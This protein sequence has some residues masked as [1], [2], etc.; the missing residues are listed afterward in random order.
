MY[1]YDMKE[2]MNVPRLA[3]GHGYK[4]PE[5]YGCCNTGMAPSIFHSRSG[6][7]VVGPELR[8]RDAMQYGLLF[9]YLIWG[10]GPQ[11]VWI[12]KGRKPAVA[13]FL[14]L[15]EAAEDTNRDLAAQY[16]DTRRKA[17]AGDLS[18]VLAP[19]EL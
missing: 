10:E 6:K 19:G 16:A 7:F 18:A 17:L 15:C 5:F 3:V 1:T 8:C 9:K 11:R 4:G 2:T 14:E 13:K 12:Y